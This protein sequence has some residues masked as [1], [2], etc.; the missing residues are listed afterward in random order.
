L[1]GVTLDEAASVPAVLLRQFAQLWRL[2]LAVDWTRVHGNSDVPKVVLPGY[3]FERQRYWLQDAISK[4]A[5]PARADVA[6]LPMD[7]WFSVPFWQPMPAYGATLIPPAGVHEGAWLVFA[8]IRA[9]WV[10]GRPFL[11]TIFHL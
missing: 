11:A 7:A 2:G 5:T 4:V 3:P 6:Q 9:Y 1:P 8:S 10:G